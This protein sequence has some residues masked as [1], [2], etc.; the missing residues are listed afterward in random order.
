MYAGIMNYLAMTASESPLLTA[1]PTGLKRFYY[2]NM[3]NDFDPAAAWL[4][5]GIWKKS[6]FDGHIP[7]ALYYLGPGW[8][9]FKDFDRTGEF[10]ILNATFVFPTEDM[11]VPTLKFV[12]AAAGVSDLRYIETLNEKHFQFCR[13][14]QS[15]NG[16]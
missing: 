14:E 7:W 13:P 15:R 10:S 8:E 16:T 12:A 5:D 1:S 6:G 11:P 2:A 4:S 9:P 3:T